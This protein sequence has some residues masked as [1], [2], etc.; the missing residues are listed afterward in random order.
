MQEQVGL[1]KMMTFRNDRMLFCFNIQ[2]SGLDFKK[3]T[4]K[5]LFSLLNIAI[6]KAMPLRAWPELY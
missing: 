1:K 2:I 6:K 4:K 3:S 5:N